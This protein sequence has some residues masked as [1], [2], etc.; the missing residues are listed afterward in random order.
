MRSLASLLG[1]ILS[2]IGHALTRAGWK[3]EVWAYRGGS[4]QYKVQ[5]VDRQGRVVQAPTSA[6]DQEAQGE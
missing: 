1:R 3:L 5:F 4:Y 2:R 6:A